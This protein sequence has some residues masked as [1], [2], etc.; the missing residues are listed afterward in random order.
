[1][2]FAL[3]IIGIVLS[4]IAALITL[5]LGIVH[6]SGGKSRTGIILGVSFVMSLIVMVL[7]I[8]EVVKRGSGKLKEGVEWIKEQESKNKNNYNWSAHENVNQ[9]YGHVPEGMKDSIPPAFFDHTSDKDNEQSYI[10]LVYP[11]RFHS[12]SA[13]MMTYVDLE[14]FD[15]TKKD[16]CSSELKCITHF[17]FD[18]KM[19]LAKRDNTEM[20]KQSAGGKND[21]PDYT[22]FLFDFSTGKCQSFMN[23]A[24]LI[25]A[26]EKR[27]Y[28]G[29]TLLDS[30]YTHYWNYAGEEGD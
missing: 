6:L 11:Y 2:N 9:Y 14:M 4:V 29:T 10:P 20:A 26:A 30:D 8:V 21:L 15:L 19:L 5:I 18:D 13:I 24:R 7:C 23:E 25:E 22:Y 17:T 3:L 12:F 1:M 27:G 16:S 28:V